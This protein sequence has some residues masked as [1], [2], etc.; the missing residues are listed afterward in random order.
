[1]QTIEQSQIIDDA[2]AWTGN[3]TN[4][5]QGLHATTQVEV[6]RVARAGFFGAKA[7]VDQDGWLNFRT[8][9]LPVLS[10]T[11]LQYAI[12]PLANPIVWTA[13]LPLTTL[14]L[15]AYPQLWQLSDS[16]TDWT[17]ARYSGAY[18]QATYTSGWPNAVTTAALTAGTSVSIPVDDSTGF[19]VSNTMNPV[20]T[21]FQSKVKIFDGSVSESVTVTSV[22]DSTHVVV[23]TL[24]NS[25]PTVGVRI[26]SIPDDIRRAVI[27]ACIQFAKERGAQAMIMGGSDTA[28]AH[29]GP[30]NS[31]TTAEYL[32]EPYKH[33]IG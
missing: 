12:T 7:F 8:D 22:P 14:V 27:F 5:P 29:G 24:A 31:I 19:A 3:F 9:T 15:G 11:Q 30:E 26:S 18:V 4:M 10:I 16:S 28:V 21:P 32:L 33:T 17:W 20:M 2:S 23:A 25:H 1:L 6:A 13:V